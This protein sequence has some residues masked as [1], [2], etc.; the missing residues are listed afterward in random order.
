MI[1]SL[2]KY[3]PNYG[4]TGDAIDEYASYTAAEVAALGLGMYNTD[5]YDVKTDTGVTYYYYMTD[6]AETNMETKYKLAV[7]SGEDEVNSPALFT[8]LIVPTDWSND[9][10]ETLGK[11]NIDV[12]VE[13]IQAKN[14][15]LPDT[16]TDLD[17]YHTW[18]NTN[19]NATP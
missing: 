4:E 8:D 2:L 6:A 14:N 13:A 7:P 17:S 12:T 5:S 16:V 18:F 15:P 9:Q 19:L 11:F 3:D 1:Q 10:V